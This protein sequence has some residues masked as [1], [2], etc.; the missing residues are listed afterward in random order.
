MVGLEDISVYIIIARAN[1]VAVRSS[2]G[3]SWG[4]PGENIYD[5]DYVKK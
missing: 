5:Y 2:G 3:R 4:I 1:V